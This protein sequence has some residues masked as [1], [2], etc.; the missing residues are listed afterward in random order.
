MF[1]TFVLVIYNKIVEIKNEILKKN[2]YFFLQLLFVWLFFKILGFFG[3]FL[4]YKFLLSFSFFILLLYFWDSMIPYIFNSKVFQ[5]YLY[6]FYNFFDICLVYELSSFG[7]GLIIGIFALY[8]QESIWN[9]FNLCICVP[10]LDYYL[11]VLVLFGFFKRFNSVLIFELIPKI[12]SGLMPTNENFFHWLDIL[13]MLNIYFLR[14]FSVMNKVDLTF[15]NPLFKKFPL[16]DCFMIS[17]KDKEGMNIQAKLFYDFILR[18]NQLGLTEIEK[19]KIIKEFLLLFEK[20]N[21]RKRKIFEQAVLEASLL[22]KNFYLEFLQGLFVGFLF[23]TLILNS[24][25]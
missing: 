1:N 22:N 7:V 2:Q 21:Q 20:E 24:F 6:I 13:E 11:I 19:S 8:F 14:K 10:N 5:Y 18:H 3:I 17:L 23:C 25:S 4:F 9:I 12:F 16:S 15:L